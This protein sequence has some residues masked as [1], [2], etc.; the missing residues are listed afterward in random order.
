MVEITP[1]L[2]IE[3]QMTT[4]VGGTGIKLTV[5]NCFYNG[6][7]GKTKTIYYWIISGKGETFEEYLD[8]PVTYVREFDNHLHAYMN[9]DAEKELTELLKKELLQ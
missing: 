6:F 9:K 7:W 8:S 5:R 4:V 3:L 1:E 2:D